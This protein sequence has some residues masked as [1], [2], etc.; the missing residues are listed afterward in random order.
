MHIFFDPNITK[1]IRVQQNKF[2]F[3]LNINSELGISF[4]VKSIIL[5]I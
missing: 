2:V 4:R 3:D 5:Q 1:Q